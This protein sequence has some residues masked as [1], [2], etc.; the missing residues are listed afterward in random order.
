MKHIIIQFELTTFVVKVIRTRFSVSFIQS[1][2]KKK[3]K[4]VTG[5]ENGTDIV[6]TQY[7]KIRGIV[8]NNSRSFLGI[9][10]AKPPTPENDLRFR[11]PEE[12]ESW[13]GIKNT[14]KIAN[15]CVQ[16]CSNRSISCYKYNQYGSPARM[17]EDCLYLNQIL[18]V[19]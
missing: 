1:C 2:S 7:G 5:Q 12:P 4:N 6:S 14:T 15:A 16:S 9:P 13:N 19:N 17:S 3:K 11:N 10:Y 18:P 8:T